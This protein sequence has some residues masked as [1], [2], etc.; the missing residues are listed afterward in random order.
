MNQIQEESKQE[1]HKAS[2][3]RVKESDFNLLDM[4]GYSMD[5]IEEQKQDCQAQDNE[6]AQK[7]NSIVDINYIVEHEDKN[8]QIE[9]T[10]KKGNSIS[11]DDKLNVLKNQVLQNHK[12]PIGQ[13]INE[14]VSASQ[15]LD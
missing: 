14:N 8:L 9:M 5:I 3:N 10:L 6:Q 1:Q 15:N 2:K 12:N 11:R 13:M 4:V 7:E